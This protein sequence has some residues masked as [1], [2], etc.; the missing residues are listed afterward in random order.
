MDAVKVMLGNAWT[1]VVGILCGGAYY[2][3]ENGA[4]FPTTKDELKKTVLAILLAGLGFTAKSATVG[5]R[6][7]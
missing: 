6:P 4:T 5:S 2:L 1:T 3:L 7:D